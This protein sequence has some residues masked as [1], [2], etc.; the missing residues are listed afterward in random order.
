VAGFITTDQGTHAAV[1]VNRTGEVKPIPEVV[2]DG[3]HI[4]LVGVYPEGETPPQLGIRDTHANL[5][6]PHMRER[7]A[8]YHADGG[9]CMDPEQ[10]A[11]AVA[12]MCRLYGLDEDDALMYSDDCGCDG[13][14]AA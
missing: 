2:G 4:A 10:R 12:E 5:I 11:A 6:E 9:N 7:R 14:D 3:R 1:L 8:R 13:G